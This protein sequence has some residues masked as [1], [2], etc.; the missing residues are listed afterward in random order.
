MTPSFTPS[1]ASHARDG[2][3]FDRVQFRAR[4]V[5]TRGSEGLKSPDETSEIVCPVVRWRAGDDAVVVLGISLGL[6]QCL[7]AFI[8]A[9][10]EIGVLRSFAVKCLDDRLRG[11]CG[12]MNGEIDRLIRVS[13]SP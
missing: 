4:D 6:H 10:T 13:W 11:H 3:S 8:R 1:S 7:T 5:G 2:C 12:F 9:R